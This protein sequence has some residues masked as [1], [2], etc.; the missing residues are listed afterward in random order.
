MS[1]LAT[2]PLIPILT[3]KSTNRLF[4]WVSRKKR[5]EG[6]SITF[7]KCIKFTNLIDNSKH[8]EVCDICGLPQNP[9]LKSDMFDD[10]NANEVSIQFCEPCIRG[11]SDLFHA[12]KKQKEEK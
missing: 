2:L 8:E 12:L 4:C 1:G 11:L 7:S 6:E 3:K 10:G 5:N 9:L